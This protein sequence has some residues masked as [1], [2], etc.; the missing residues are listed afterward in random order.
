MSE[1]PATLKYS[2][3]HEWI[4]LSDD[5]ATIGITD[6]AQALLG[7]IVFI[8]LPEVGEHISEDGECGVVESVKAASDLFAPIGGE[9]VE[10]NENLGDAPEQV[11]ET[12][13]EAWILKIKIDNASDIDNLLDATQYQAVVDAE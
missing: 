13:Y 3:S 6:H 8:E 4:Q 10:V 5:I 7:D 9:V 11:N 12:P 2:N 1:I